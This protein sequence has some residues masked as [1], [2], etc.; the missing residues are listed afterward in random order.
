MFTITDIVSDIE[1]HCA[2]N[3]L[4]EDSFSYRIVFYTN[5]DGI[6]TKHYIDSAYDDLRKN[7]ES[8]IRNNLS[9]TNIVMVAQ[10]T[11]LKNGRCIFLQSRPYGFNLNEYFRQIYGKSRKKKALY[12]RYVLNAN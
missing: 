12:G 4:N 11:V 1:R 7:L 3:N 2:V 9:L 5:E 6:R 8:I 10:T